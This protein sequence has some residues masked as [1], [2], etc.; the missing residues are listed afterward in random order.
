MISV[1]KPQSLAPLT[2]R[3]SR[4]LE[5]AVMGPSIRPSGHSELSSLSAR[6][7]RWWRPCPSTAAGPASCLPAQQTRRAQTILD[8]YSCPRPWCECTLFCCRLAANCSSICGGLTGFVTLQD[9]RKNSLPV[10]GLIVDSCAICTGRV[11]LID[12]PITRFVSL[13]NIPGSIVNVTAQQVRRTARSV[14][15]SYLHAEGGSGDR[16]FLS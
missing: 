8:V 16:H 11:N 10:T 13:S 15:P 3:A 14:N 4:F 9:C 7:T 1:R 6:T 12:L 2:R 5:A